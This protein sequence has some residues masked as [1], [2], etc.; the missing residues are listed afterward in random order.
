MVDDGVLQ[1]GGSV[2]EIAQLLLDILADLDSNRERLDGVIPTLSLSLSL[3]YLF[4]VDD[5]FHGNLL[6]YLDGSAHAALDVV[7]KLLE[8]L[9]NQTESVRERTLIERSRNLSM[10]QLT[11]CKECPL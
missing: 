9:G 1:A 6:L 2:A 4:K 3:S 5:V 8:R 10:N 11:T 7:V